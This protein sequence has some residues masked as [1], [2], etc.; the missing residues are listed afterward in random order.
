[1]WRSSKRRSSSSIIISMCSCLEISRLLVR[2]ALL[3]ACVVI[4]EPAFLGYILAADQQI[5]VPTL[6]IAMWCNTGFVVRRSESIP[7][8]L[9]AATKDPTDHADAT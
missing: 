7:P 4:R 3:S 5:R 6:V 8:A 2:A 9:V 1:M